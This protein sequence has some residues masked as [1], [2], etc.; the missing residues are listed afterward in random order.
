MMILLILDYL[1]A[2]SLVPSLLSITELIKACFLDAFIT[3][4]QHAGTCLDVGFDMVEVSV[5]IPSPCSHML[6]KVLLPFPKAKLKF[7][8]AAD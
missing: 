5:Y 4:L 7:Q 2:S 6:F 8:V 3:C 1:K